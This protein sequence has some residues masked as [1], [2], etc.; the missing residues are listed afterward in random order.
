M[1]PCDCNNTAVT[2]THTLAQN[3]NNKTKILAPPR[4][5]GTEKTR[6][7]PTNRKIKKFK[8][9]KKRISRSPEASWVL[10]PLPHGEPTSTLHGIKIEPK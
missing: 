10:T 1:R 5:R 7:D 2:H 3:K 4:G 8:K 9:I 6:F